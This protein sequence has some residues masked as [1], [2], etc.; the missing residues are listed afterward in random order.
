MVS[1]ASILRVYN[2]RGECVGGR[3]LQLSTGKHYV[4]TRDAPD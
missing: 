3:G 4:I 2:N 1:A